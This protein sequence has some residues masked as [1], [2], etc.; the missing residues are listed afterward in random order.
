MVGVELPA[1]QAFAKT[2]HRIDD[3]MLAIQRPNRVSREGDAGSHRVDHLLHHHTDTNTGDAQAAFDTV[4]Q[5][6]LRKPGRPAAANRRGQLPHAAAAEEGRE[7][8]GETVPGRVLVDAAR[9]NCELAFGQ[10][11]GLE[12]LAQLVLDQR[13]QRMHQEEFLHA[14]GKGAEL[15]HVRF[16]TQFVREFVHLDE[17]VEGVGGNAEPRRHRNF[18]ARHMREIHGLATAAKRKRLGWIA[19]VEDEFL[20]HAI[21]SFRGIAQRCA[22]RQMPAALSGIR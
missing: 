14:F 22:S 9:A 4:S 20:R 17:Q 21:I 18:G 19:A 8:S 5:C 2:E 7:L 10:L 11:Q 16:G 1:N 12:S 6:A 13:R 3:E 15:V